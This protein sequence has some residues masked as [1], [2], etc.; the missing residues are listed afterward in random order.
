MRI[1]QVDLGRLISAS[2]VQS[3]AS[4]VAVAVGQD[5]NEEDVELLDLMELLLR[6]HR[7]RSVLHQALH[8]IDLF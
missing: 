2:S 4:I 6:A 8:I 3:S 7:Q 5:V 1:R